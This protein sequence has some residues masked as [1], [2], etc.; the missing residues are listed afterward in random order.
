M[1]RN[2]LRLLI[3]SSLLASLTAPVWAEQNNLG[4]YNRKA[5]G[6]FWYQKEPEPPVPEKEPEPPEQP[7]VVIVAPEAKPEEEPAPVIPA[8]PAP[9]SSAWLKSNMPKYLSS[10]I[11]NPTVENVKA[12]LYL[13]RV[14]LD[15]AE[16]YS[17]AT[18][19]ANIGDPFLD[20]TTRRPGSSF[21]ISSVDARAGLERNKLVEEVGQMA[22]IFFFFKS[23]CNMCEM[24]APLLKSLEEHEGFTIIPVSLDGKNMSNSPWEQFRTDMGHAEQLGVQNLPAMFLAT[25]DG[26]FAALG[27]SLYSLPELQQRIISAARRENW[28]SEEQFNKTRPILNYANLANILT[29]YPDQVDT[30]LTNLEQAA[31]ENGFIDQSTLLDFITNRI[32]GQYP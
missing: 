10:A 9:L 11:D 23:D 8:A 29:P 4:F 16:Q 19:M 32:E 7:A 21:A 18:Q 24:Q 17:I 26:Q 3:C 1:K 31:D 2:T 27:Q 30:G 6:W 14:A 5:E 15:K 25:P 20:E 28:I 22:G 13:Q 12:Y